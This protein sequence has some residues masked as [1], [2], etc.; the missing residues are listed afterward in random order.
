MF[1]ARVELY[2]SMWASIVG[3]KCSVHSKL[4]GR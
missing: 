2:C 1:Q 3:R 4:F